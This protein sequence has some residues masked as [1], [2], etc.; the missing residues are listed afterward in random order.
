MLVTD[1]LGN[2][3]DF[4]AHPSLGTFPYDTTAR[5]LVENA[6]GR[7][8]A[9][10]VSEYVVVIKDCHATTCKVKMDPKYISSIPDYDRPVIVGS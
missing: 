1:G 9:P 2:L 8:A 7:N 3:A 4:S 5:V 10:H 6:D